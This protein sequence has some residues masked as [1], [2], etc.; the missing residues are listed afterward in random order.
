MTPDQLK[1]LADSEFDRAVLKKNFKESAEAKLNVAFAGGLFVAD[2]VTISFLNA[3][4]EEIVYLKDSYDNP[5]RVNSLELLTLLKN[6]YQSTMQSWY[7]EV[8]KSNRIRRAA[9]V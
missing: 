6:T 4:T 9:N 3:C 5:V 8:E 1:L 7:E 2:P